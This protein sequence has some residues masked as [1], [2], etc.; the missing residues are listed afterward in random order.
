MLV[1]LANETIAA[2]GQR[3]AGLGIGCRVG[4]ICSANGIVRAGETS[5]SVRGLNRRSVNNETEQQKRQHSRYWSVRPDWV[6][7]SVPRHDF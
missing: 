1:K 6:C 4:K 5:V 7:L 3:V 2:A